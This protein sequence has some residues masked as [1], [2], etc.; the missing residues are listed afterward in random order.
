M[1][2]IFSVREEFMLYQPLKVLLFHL[3]RGM[4]I[5]R[6]KGLDPAESR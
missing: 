2:G 4:S 5:K 3:V 6:G 1:R